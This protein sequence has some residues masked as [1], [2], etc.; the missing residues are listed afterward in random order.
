MLVRG[1][2]LVLEVFIYELGGNGLAPNVLIPSD[3]TGVRCCGPCNQLRRLRMP[4]LERRRW[5]QRHRHSLTRH[6]ALFGIVQ[7]VLAA[8]RAA[9]QLDGRD[10]S[11]PFL[12]E[13]SP[14]EH[15]VALP[16]LST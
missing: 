15:M 12:M 7:T 4:L 8:V 16:P 14:G 11:Q 10:S 2:R 13:R 6:S 1:L 5:S 3:I 9:V